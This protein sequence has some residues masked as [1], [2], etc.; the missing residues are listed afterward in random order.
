MVEGGWT[1]YSTAYCD[2]L[3]TGGCALVRN[4]G[5]NRG[6][7]MTTSL[8]VLRA[9]LLSSAV[10][11][12]SGA[13][14]AADLGGGS[15]KDIPEAKSDFGISVTG[16]ATTDYM[17][18]GITQNENDPS[19]NASITLT[20]K[21]FYLGFAGAAVDKVTTSN[22]GSMETDVVGGIKTSYRGI[23]FDFGFI[24]YGY[25][26]QWSAGNVNY[27]GY[28]ADFLEL[29]AS[30][31]T[32]I[33]RDTTVTGTVYWSPDYSGEVGS[34]W[35]VE[36]GISQP[37]PFLGLVASGTL[38]YVSS[39]ND[40]NGF[41][42]NIGDDAYSYW[43]AGL[44]KTFMEKYTFDVRYWGTDVANTAGANWLT[45]DRVVGSFTFAY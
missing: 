29:K 31:S 33:F 3:P 36:G 2:E 8:K 34:T 12:M 25:P 21:M 37:L 20:Y 11:M 35:T 14:L 28:N 4:P 44:S 16:G 26:N 32:K 10:V 40:H 45:G 17:F 24:Y 6:L 43:N 41:S 39:E 27:W 1:D 19:V 5:E 9:G 15:L 42:A 38:G 13:A 30:A 7:I 18:R 23:D 22:G